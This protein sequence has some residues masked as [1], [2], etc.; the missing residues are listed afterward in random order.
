MIT[1][2]KLQIISMMTSMCSAFTSSSSTLVPRITLKEYLASPT[3]DRPILIRDIIP[4][5][6][7]ESLVDSL[8]ETCGEEIVQMQRKRRRKSKKNGN[9]VTTEIYDVSLQESIGY[10]M[11]STHDDSYFA[12]CEGLLSTSTVVSELNHVFEEIREAPFPHQENWFNFFPPHLKPTDAIILAGAGSTSTFHRDPFEWTGTSLCLEGTKIWRFVTPP[13]EGINVVDEA[14]DSYRLDSIAWEENDVS[15]VLS[16][17]WQS[18]MMLYES[19][20][21]MFPTAYEW[22][23]REEEDASLFRKELESLST[24]MLLP[25]AKAAS[26]LERIRINSNEPQYATAI[27]QTGDLLIIPAHCWH[28]TYAPMP[29]VAIASQRCSARVDGANVVGH[30]LELFRGVSEIPDLLKQS[31]YSEGTGR[32]VV[33][34]LLKYALNN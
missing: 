12:F 16:A 18:D 24:S 9:K 2:T 27:Q 3:Y 7:V 4:Q 8:M 10:L 25:D 22:V 34:E 23:E 15:N 19:I 33:G 30:V 17:G 13:S 31:E 32:E 11:D 1:A 26:A 20:D 14:L 28:Q 6:R 21:E 5:S 29:S